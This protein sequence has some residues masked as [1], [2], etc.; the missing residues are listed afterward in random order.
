VEVICYSSNCKGSNDRGD[1]ILEERDTLKTDIKKEAW[2]TTGF[3]QKEQAS[4]QNNTM[5]QQDVG[6]RVRMS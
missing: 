5:Q 3:S 2:E 6:P 1:S 4:N